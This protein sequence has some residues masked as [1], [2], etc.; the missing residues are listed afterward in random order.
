MAVT[1]IND[2]D[3]ANDDDNGGGDSNN[4]RTTPTSWIG[5]KER[6]RQAY[7]RGDHDVALQA[8][9]QALHHRHHQHHSSSSLSS[10]NLDQQILLSNMVAC[11]LKLGGSAQAEAAVENAKR[12]IALN[13]QWAKGYVRLASAY[14]ALGQHSGAA[15]NPVDVNSDESQSQTQGAR[16]S[17]S[18]DAC[19]ALQRALQLDPGNPTARDMLIRELR[20]RDH[21]RQS[22][23]SS[24]SRSNSYSNANNGDGQESS[25]SGAPRPSAPP[26]HMDTDS[27][28]YTGTD[29][30][31][32]NN[33]TSNNTRQ[34]NQHR[35]EHQ[36][37]RAPP[38]DHSSSDN[39]SNSN[40]DHDDVDIDDTDSR[41]WKE[42]LQFQI[43]RG[44]FW[45]SGQSEDV[46]SVLKVALA[47]VVSE[48]SAMLPAQTNNNTMISR[49]CQQKLLLIYGTVFVLHTAITK[50][51]NLFSNYLLSLLITATIRN[52]R[53][54]H[55]CT[56]ITRSLLSISPF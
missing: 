55:I 27:N 47:I 36:Q 20:S 49:E 34:Q 28:M 51:S 46:Q 10:S 17:H 39:N 50:K 2:G 9:T 53:F 44:K 5:W 8:Y 3:D 4:A 16:T 24:S 31:N 41:T 37:Y 22:N 30:G 7:I 38:R 23:S 43:Q 42:R 40:M 52:A 35:Q 21:G 13:D 48:S 11:R 1:T 19:N 33:S 25:N 56:H 45:Y 14:I 29:D 12:C 54:I 6:G 26:Q 32:S 15:H 18:N